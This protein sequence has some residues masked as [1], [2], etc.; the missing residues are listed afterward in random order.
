M[1]FFNFI[2]TVIY[3]N[4]S[5]LVSLIIKSYTFNLFLSGTFHFP[6]Q[7]MKTHHL[8]QHMV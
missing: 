5:W 8:H 1:F 7:L 2:F 3:F 6:N 4:N